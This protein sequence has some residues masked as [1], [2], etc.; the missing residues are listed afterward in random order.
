VSR[1]PSQKPH[2]LA[3]LGFEHWFADG[4]SR[5]R[6][7]VVPGMLVPG[8]QIVRIGL[9]AVLADLASGQPETG[10]VTPTTDLSVHVA[11]L[12]PMETITLAARVLKSGATLMFVETLLRADDDPEP[13]ATSLATFMSRPVVQMPPLEPAEARLS[14]P[15]HE[16]IG[17]VVLRPGVAELALR[18]DILNDHHH[19][20]VQGGLLAALAEICATS[21]WGHGE[22]V[23]EA[24]LVTD[25]DIRYLNRVKV[26]PVRASAQIVVD[27][28]RGTV[29]DV[30]LVDAGSG[31]R[32]VA[33]ATTTCIP[34][35]VANAAVAGTPP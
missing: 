27:G 29:V 31:M 14:Q 5:G 21:L 25:L 20:T 32:P 8:T 16:R 33:H 34:L 22:A 17:A 15:L 30:T 11:R 10:P 19:G 24:H 12:R 26:G 4:L 1:S 7:H 23:G 28:W 3:E 6:V 18:D 2:V 13:F 9:L 35:R